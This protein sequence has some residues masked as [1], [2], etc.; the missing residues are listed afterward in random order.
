M[1][2]LLAVDEAVRRVVGAC[3]PVP[4]EQVALA[5]AH[6]RALAEDVV[7]RVTKPPFDGSAMDGYA[8]RAADLATAPA[9]LKV[10]GTSH[11]GGA[12]PG[13]V[14]AGEA[15]RIFTGAPMPAGADAVLIQENAD[16]EG[17]DLEAGDPEAGGVVA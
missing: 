12:F 4:S 3:R 2:S 1:T 7:A 9:R 8:V 15:V 14:G 11:A 13:R 10:I 6:G 5:D 16:L 17:G